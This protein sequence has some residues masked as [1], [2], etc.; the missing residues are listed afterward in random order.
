MTVAEIRILSGGAAQ[1][2]LHALGPAF[3]TG[4]KCRIAAAFGAVGAMRQRL[5][6]DA[7]CDLVILTRQLIETLAREGHVDPASITDIGVV[8]TGIGIRTGDA[9]PAVGT[10]DS[11]REALRDADAIYFPDAKL[12]T[13][14]I[15]FAGV[16]ERLGLA[17]D[18]RARVRSF[19]NGATAMA[20]MAAQRGG[21]PIGCTQVTEIIA[22]PGVTL[23]APLPAGLGLD[24]VYTAGVAARAAAPELARKLAAVL[25][26][27]ESAEARKTAGFA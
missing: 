17:D 16:M 13:A 21:R 18:L 27:T 11:L 3:E 19:P 5:V 12:A 7:P 20:A 25:A 8:A 2:L 4:E 22:T 24:T 10:A 23:V 1:G 15:H 6:E 14:G 9:P 26:G